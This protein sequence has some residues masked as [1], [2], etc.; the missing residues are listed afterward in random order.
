MIPLRL[1]K[2]RQMRLSRYSSVR[3]ARPGY[4]SNGRHLTAI[5]SPFKATEFTKAAW[6]FKKLAQLR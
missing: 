5:T 1:L 2:M 4:P 3:A 6:K